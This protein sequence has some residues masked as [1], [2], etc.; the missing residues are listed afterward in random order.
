MWSET[1]ALSCLKI[2][3]KLLGVWRTV[4]GKCVFGNGD[5]QHLAQLPAPASLL[6]DAG[7]TRASVQTFL[8]CVV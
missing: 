3:G 6:G 8:N 2:H 5:L 4:N 1:K 7:M